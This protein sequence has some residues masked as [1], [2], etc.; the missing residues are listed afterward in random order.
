MFY[1][2]SLSVRLHKRSPQ[3]K[4]LGKNKGFKASVVVRTLKRAPTQTK[5]AKQGLRKKQRF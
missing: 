4:D 5:S 2:E 1:I 3:N